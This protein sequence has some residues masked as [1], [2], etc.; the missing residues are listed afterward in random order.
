VCA[1]V[2]VKPGDYIVGDSDGVVVVP[3][4][5]ATQVV[6]LISRY[7][8]KES[9]MIPIIEREKSMLRALELYNRY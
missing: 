4:E 2:P 1:G 8:D 7:D 3:Q 9:K 6:E 5:A